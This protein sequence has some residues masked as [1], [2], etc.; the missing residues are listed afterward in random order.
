M[1]RE[2]VYLFQKDLLLEMRQKHAIGGVLLYVLSTIFVAYLSFR[3]IIDINTWNALFWIILLFTAF[4]ATANSFHQTKDGQALYWYTLASPRGV[5]LAKM[6]YNI[7]LML[8]LGLLSLFFFVLFIGGEL[9]WQGDVASFVI[10]VVLGSAGIASVLTMI[11]AIASK[12]NNALGIM[13]ILGMPVVLPLILTVIRLSRNALMGIPVMDNWKNLLFLVMI[14]A[15][16]IALSY[17]LFPY[18]WRD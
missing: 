18:L 5:I 12:T 7:A 3:Q 9:L 2:I 1:L 16:S 13:A 17:V 11:A 15:I 8:V 6:L 4:N 14:N 10:S